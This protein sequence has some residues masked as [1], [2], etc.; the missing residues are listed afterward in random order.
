M[1]AAFECATRSVLLLLVKCA[2]GGVVVGQAV[3]STQSPLK[4]WRRLNDDEHGTLLRVAQRQ[5][6]FIII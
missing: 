3:S 1:A 5:P 4:L 6:L 2:G